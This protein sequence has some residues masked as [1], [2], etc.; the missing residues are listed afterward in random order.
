MKK[1]TPKRKIQSGERPFRL[2]TRDLEII[3]S[4]NQFRFLKP[5]QLQRLLFPE[6]KQIRSVQRRLTGLFDHQYLNRIVPPLPIEGGAMEMVYYLGENGIALLEKL[7]VQTAPYSR[8]AD[9]KSIFLDHTFE[10]GDFQ[11]A[12]TLALKN[13][14]KTEL[15]RFI[16]DYALNTR[17]DTATGGERYYLRDR[18]SEGQG[19]P[20]YIV[21]PD[22][23]IVLGGIGEYQ[24]Y[25]SLYFL[26]VDRSTESLDRIKEKVTGYKLYHRQG[27]HKRFGEFKDFTVLFQAKS[28]ARIN[29]IRK[30]LVEVAGAELFWYTTRNQVTPE[31]ITLAP[32]WQNQAGEPRSI[33]KS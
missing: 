24:K 12:L 32:I 20:V 5:S 2:T 14:P 9:V 30:H 18:V 1:P 15:V 19:R 8:N 4:V 29:N 16:P 26:E 6:T 13:H 21:Y 23:L 33:L 22:A 31:T 17:V 7:D 11:L 28:Q 10:I 27:I 25:Q 3:R